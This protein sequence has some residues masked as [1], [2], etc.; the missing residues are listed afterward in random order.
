[1]RTK[2]IRR[3][4]RIRKTKG[5]SRVAQM[6]MIITSSC[7]AGVKWV[8]PFCLAGSFASSRVGR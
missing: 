5:S 7:A 4:L 3:V 6:K 8:R 1:M 2:I